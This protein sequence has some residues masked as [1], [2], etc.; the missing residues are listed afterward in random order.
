MY[1]RGRIGR[2]LMPTGKTDYLQQRCVFCQGK[3]LRI[4]SI[5]G[6]IALEFGVS[7]IEI[8][9]AGIR[10]VSSPCTTHHCS[11]AGTKKYAGSVIACVP[12]HIMVVLRG[13]DEKSDKNNYFDAITE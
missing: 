2:P 9:K 11:L 5:L 4:I 7:D 6:N 8:S 1:R 10:F 13:F 3:C 12:N